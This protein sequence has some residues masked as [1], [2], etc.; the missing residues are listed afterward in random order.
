MFSLELVWHQAYHSNTIATMPH[1]M[2]IP[3]HTIVYTAY[4]DVILR[5]AAIFSLTGLT[6]YYLNINQELTSLQEYGI[7]MII[8]LS[9]LY[10]DI[11]DTIT[12][13]LTAYKITTFHTR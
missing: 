11:R 10:I 7:D 2:I 5:P 9:K 1:N 6:I 12:D 8:V 3:I 13:T 4:V